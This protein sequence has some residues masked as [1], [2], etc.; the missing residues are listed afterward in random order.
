MMIRRDD[1]DEMQKLK[2]DWEQLDELG[3]HLPATI[4]EIK[5]QVT[6]YQAKQK[7]AF[8]RELAIFLLTAVFIM[9]AIVMSIVQ[10][11]LLFIVLQVGAIFLAPI[12]LY[13]LSKRKKQE[14]KV[15]L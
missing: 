6:V 2:H 3:E 9:S 5:E 14:E 11:P 10:A 15:L 7:K 13:L 8:Y 12:I 1:P 4:A